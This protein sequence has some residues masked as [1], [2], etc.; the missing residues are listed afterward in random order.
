MKEDSLPKLVK[1]S[2][3]AV[4]QT[5]WK[6]HI[7]ILH[8]ELN[9]KISANKYPELRRLH[10]GKQKLEIFTDYSAAA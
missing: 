9:N 8:S 4:V 5:I 3:M 2:M 7:C 1:D 6:S 10:E